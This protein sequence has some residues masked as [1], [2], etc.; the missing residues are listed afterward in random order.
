MMWLS[1]NGMQSVH[2]K[3]LELVE[4]GLH[5]SPKAAEHFC[6]KRYNPQVYHPVLVRSQEDEWWHIENKMN[7]HHSGMRVPQNPRTRHHRDTSSSGLTNCRTYRSRGVLLD[8]CE[9]CPVDQQ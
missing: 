8:V 9:S 3:L 5:P 7:E 2:W 6:Q 1:H 4:I